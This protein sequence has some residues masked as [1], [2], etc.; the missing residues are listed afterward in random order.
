MA[1]KVVM[2]LAT[3]K[4]NR[5]RP[6]SNQ[7]FTLIEV[8][9]VLGLMAFAAAAVITNFT[10]LAERGDSLSSEETLQSA[11][12]RARFIAANE[13]I[14]TELRFDKESGSLSVYNNEMISESFPLDESFK[15]GGPAEILFYLV[16]PSE[17]LGSPSD[18]S[19]TRLETNAVQFAPDRSS[20]PF[21]ADID[22]GSGTATRMIFDP[23]S[24]LLIIP[25]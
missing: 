21:V 9:L 8:V 3:G 11:V 6:P 22:T 15:K 23:F 17:G 19:R 1:L 7:G 13:R 24:S 18:A 4:F 25:K 16:P 2:I 14:I 12:R 5:K 10:A 20:S